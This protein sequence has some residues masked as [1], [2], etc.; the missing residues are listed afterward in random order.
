M[1]QRHYITTF[2]LKAASLVCRQWWRRMQEATS[3]GERIQRDTRQF[4]SPRGYKLS[5]EQMD[6]IRGGMIDKMC[7]NPTGFD[8]HIDSN[9]R[10]SVGSTAVYFLRGAM[11]A[12]PDTS[13]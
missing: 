6:N 1:K 10:I 3:G 7:H 8:P 5:T 2:S 13:S 9:K 12:S 11:I 4:E